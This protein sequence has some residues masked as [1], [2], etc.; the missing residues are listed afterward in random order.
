[1]FIFIYF[2][3]TDFFIYTSLNYPGFIYVT[4]FFFPFPFY[5]QITRRMNENRRSVLCMR[6]ADI[7]SESAPANYNT[8]TG[9]K[10]GSL[11]DLPT[12]KFQAVSGLE[13]SL[14]VIVD[15]LLTTYVKDLCPQR[16][17]AANEAGRNV[18][19]HE[20]S[21]LRTA[22]CTVYTV[23]TRCRGPLIWLEDDMDGGDKA[24]PL[25]KILRKELQKGIMDIDFVTDPKLIDHNFVNRLFNLQGA[26][27]EQLNAAYEDST[28]QILQKFKTSFWACTAVLDNLL[29]Q[30]SGGLQVGVDI[31]A[32]LQASEEYQTLQSDKTLLLSQLA[33]STH[34][35]AV[36]CSDFLEALPDTLLLKA[37]TGDGKWAL[38]WG[39]DL[40]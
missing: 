36:E 29:K 14:P 18:E 27:L 6:F 33:V 17:F 40:K 10:L 24:H 30:N 20:M 8:T 13:I 22:L 39:E 15:T 1:M 2:K 37:G 26:D 16:I 11:A 7:N 19:T 3:L 12:I 35:E 25:V 28:R 31:P 38:E 32:L 4:L 23:L 21:M 9:E 5:L 34:D